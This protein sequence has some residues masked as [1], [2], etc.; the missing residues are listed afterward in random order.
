MPVLIPISSIVVPPRIR[1]TRTPP[2]SLLMSIKKE[3]LIEPITVTPAS[4]N[5]DYIL[6]HGLLRL[7]C[8]IDMRIKEVPAIIDKDV[9]T[10]SLRYTEMLCNHPTPYAMEEIVDFCK[11]LETHHKMFIASEIEELIHFKPGQYLKLKAILESQMDDIIDAVMKGRLDIDRAFSK[12]EKLKKIAE[13]SMKENPELD[14]AD[15]VALPANKQEVGKRHPLAPALRKAIEARDNFTCQCCDV[16][17]MAYSK[18]FE[19]HHIIPV[20]FD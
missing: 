19:V 8:L 15:L 11:Y 12:L 3:G 1:Q 6:V 2:E 16:K 7:L 17:G 20:Y 9:D 4:N 18:I 10:K 13:D 5:K 14:F